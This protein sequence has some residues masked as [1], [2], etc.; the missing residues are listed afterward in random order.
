MRY[1]VALLL[2]FLCVGCG[3]SN[4][5]KRERTL[6]TLNVEADRWNGG[7]GF[8]TS[9]VDAYGNRILGS[10]DRGLLNYVLEVRSVGRDGLPKNHDDIT[11]SRSIRHGES[12]VSDQAA[13]DVGKVSGGVTS[14]A[15]EGIKEGF[16]LKRKDKR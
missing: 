5:E 12:V 9:A 13:R 8:T 3:P 4:S 1:S 2:M 11:V 16:G 15:I 6:S 7:K 10:V 14:G